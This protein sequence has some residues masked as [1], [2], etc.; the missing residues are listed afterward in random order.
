MNSTNFRLNQQLKYYTFLSMLYVVLMVTAQSIAFR[1]MQIGLF[2]E[3]GGIFI[4][5]ASFAVSDI[6]AE[7]YG[8]SLARRCIFFGL[9]S[10]AFFGIITTLIN[11]MPYPVWWNEKHS[12]EI[13]FGNSILVFLS[14]LVAVVTGTI[15]NTQL[16]GK[17]KLLAKGR[18]FSLRSLFSSAIGEFILTIIIVAIALAPV[19]GL[20]KGLALFVNMFIFKVCFSIIFIVPSS[21]FVVLFKKLDNIDVYE[22]NVSLNVFNIVAGKGHYKRNIIKFN[23]AMRTNKK[24]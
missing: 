16:I 19:V 8:P 5:P 24:P 14:N 13:V 15:L 3:P 18:F 23:S 4:F 7:V 21:F 1:M 10:Q 17:T 20:E 6:I 9:I 12:F 22:E 11:H 2:L